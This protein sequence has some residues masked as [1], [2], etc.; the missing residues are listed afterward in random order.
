MNADQRYSVRQ[1]AKMAGVSARTL[2]YYDEIGLLSPQRNPVNGYRLYERTDVLRLQQILFLRELGFGLEAV[3]AVIDRPDFNLLDALEQHRVE[4]QER[5]KRLARLLETVERTILH[6]KG[7]IEMEP[8]ELFDGLSEDKQKEY[9]I[10]A[11]RRYGE[12]PVN[13]SN[14]RWNSYPTEKKQ[15]ILNEGREIYAAM[16]E[17]IPL[18]PG[19]EQAQ[20]CVARWHQNLRNFYEPTAEILLGLGDLYNEDAAFKTNFDRIHPDLAAFMRESIRIYCRG[21]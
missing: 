14:Q 19:S 17:A 6:I 15:A 2:H 3:R 20:E 12:E 1:V 5:Q 8:D 21:K 7:K 10:E 13:E 16:A 11:R 18:G 9:E 4:L